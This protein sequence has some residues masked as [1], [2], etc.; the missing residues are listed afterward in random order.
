[1]S[2]GL[3]I[4]S[5]CFCNKRLC[6]FSFFFLSHSTYARIFIARRGQPRGHLAGRRLT[7]TILKLLV[8]FFHSSLFAMMRRSQACD[9]LPILFSLFW[10]SILTLTPTSII[11]EKIHP[12]DG[13]VICHLKTEITH[14]D[15]GGDERQPG[16]GNEGSGEES[17]RPRR[18][19]PCGVEIG[20]ACGAEDPTAKRAKVDEAKEEEDPLVRRRE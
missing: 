20:M 5:S 15:R 9:A 17:G 3:Q 6:F 1:M 7:P 18:R 19:G 4:A 2:S 11:P 12:G 10:S 13:R 8:T 16:Q 14:A